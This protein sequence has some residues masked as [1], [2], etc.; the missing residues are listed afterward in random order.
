MA[1]F[2][3]TQDP[4]HLKTP[5]PVLIEQGT[6]DTIVLPVFTDALARE[7]RAAG[8]KVTYKRYPGLGHAGVQ[9]RHEPTTDAYTYVKDRLG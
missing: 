6:G 8:A 7:L 2:L 1:R 3:D 9:L 5:T 4:S